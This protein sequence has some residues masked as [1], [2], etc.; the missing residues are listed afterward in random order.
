[1]RDAREALH[2]GIWDTETIWTELKIRLYSNFFLPY[3]HVAYILVLIYRFLT[4]SWY[5]KTFIA[6]Y[7]KPSSLV[8]LTY[9]NHSF[10][11]LTTITPHSL[12]FPFLILLYNKSIGLVSH[13]QHS[14]FKHSHNFL[15]VTAK[16]FTCLFSVSSRSFDIYRTWE[17]ML[18]LLFLF[19]SLVRF[20][21]FKV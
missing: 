11:G 13:H 16:C 2:R 9:F 5:C 4:W 19:F 10:I 15:G 17:F 1:M 6:L 20:S 8:T 14:S 12:Q 18:S 7:Y 3:N 21:M